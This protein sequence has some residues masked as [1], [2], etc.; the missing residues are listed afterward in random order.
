MRKLSLLFAFLLTMLGGTRVW[1]DELTV[2]NG[3][4]KNAYIPFMGQNADYGVKGEYVVPASDLTAMA[5]MAITSM[6][7]YVETNN[8]SSKPNYGPFQIFL[9]EINNATPYTSSSSAFQGLTDATVV[10]EGT[11]VASSGELLITFS[12]TYTYNG[13][14]LLIGFYKDKGGYYLSNN[15]YGVNQEGYTANSTYS[16]SGIN[17]ISTGTGRTFIP[18][19]TF[20]YE[21][22]SPYK[23]PATL[24]ISSISS[25]SAVVEWTAGSNDNSETGWDLE[26]KKSSE[27][28]WN[29]V[30]HGLS[31]STLSQT[32]SG[33]SDNTSYDVRVKALYS[34][35][36]E[37]DWRATSF[38]TA[39]VATPA[40][41]FTDNF[42]SDKEWELIN[43]TQTNK[44]VR[45]TATNNGGSN[46]L[47]ISNDGG[48][49]NAYGH[50]ASMTFATKLFAFETGNFTIAYDWKAN[51]ES[52]YDFMRVALVPA[53]EELT[54]G[55]T[56]SS[57]SYNGLPSGWQALDGGSKLNLQSDW[58]SKSVD[59][60]IES[61][62]SYQVVFAWKNDGN[63][64][65]TTPAAAIDNFKILGSA[66]VLELGGDVTGT[67]LAFGSV[68]ETTNKTITITNSGKVA[69]E[70]ITLTE[71]S[72]AN[73]V[74]SYTAL[75]K[76]TLAA[77]ESMDVT[78]TFSGSTANDYTGSFRVTADDCSAI[79]V[80]VTATYS[81]SPATIAVKLGDNVVSGTQA[82]GS[83]GKQAV[84]TFTVVNDGDQTLNVTIASNNTTDFT[85]SPASLAVTGHN[86]GT[87]TVTFVYP[88][89]NPVIN[90]EKS[91]NITVT[92]SNDG[93]SDV[94]FDVTGTRIELWSE[95]F[96]GTSTPTGW[97]NPVSGYTAWTFSEGVAYGGY[98]Y[99]N[100]ARIQ[101]PLLDVESGKSLT[102]EAKGEVSYSEFTVYAYS[103]DGVLVKTSN[104][105]S[106]VQASLTNF[107]TLTVDGLNAGKY[108]FV[109]DAYKTYVDRV[110]GFKLATL[111]AHEAEVESTTI[112]ATG[113]QY[114]AYT[115]SVNVK[116]TG[117]NSEELT[118][119]FFI[120]NTQY[121]S[122]VV[123]TVN[124]GE[125]ETFTVTF[126]PDAAVSGDAYFTFTNNDI[127]LTTSTTAV[128]IAAAT[129]LDE[130]VGLPDGLT[131]GTKP[132]LVLNYTVKAGWN[133]IAVPFALTDDILTSIFG[134]GYSVF[135]FDSYDN[136][137]IAFKPS[138]NF[139]AGY[140]YLVFVET[141]TAHADGV[142][143]FDVNVSTLTEESDYRNPVRFQTTYAPMAAG[144]MTG[145]YG[146]T[147]DGEIRKAGSGASLKGF[148]AYFTG[149]PAGTQARIAFLGD[150]VPTGINSIESVMQTENVYNLN[151]QKVNT[152][153]KGIY[154]VNGKKVL[155]K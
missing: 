63:G 112:P 69:M 126:T 107:T 155:V 27:T 61:A 147:S 12:E 16:S 76:I 42:E 3:T 99:P 53:S 111:E 80:T 39:K 68:S 109:F 43:G 102:I 130:M 146:V 83:V 2:A 48:T 1:A 44:W 25:N 119:K 133:T 125:T 92:P 154:I 65:T 47:Y 13:G 121:G 145:N 45:G 148:R 62:G 132:S 34:N 77:N 28:T 5:G 26:Y 17:S 35:N 127:A 81:N 70:N 52:N 9:K 73:N 79:D 135:E 94:T 57:F 59:I 137:V 36:N 86:S 123:K 49:T 72:D 15:F 75:P 100:N 14:N 103:K 143:L 122:D 30:H 142:K 118:A 134:T 54:A 18:K 41:G 10:Y 24:T 117:A 37:S 96:E 21:A 82:F 95:E 104:F 55:T 108:Y 33:L 153:Q 58:Q 114:V 131:T 88:T 46:A 32:I 152:P 84:K 29:E 11:I 93:L 141:A 64:G 136:N 101:T 60:T 113:N 74:F 138:T 23:K 20:T 31:V 124:S 144:S 128:T 89:E 98:S 78:V 7:L 4:T 149:V 22:T 19:T 67:T 90:E 85:V 106:N 140:P 8:S 51:G 71:T 110:E 50:S 115:A 56:P 38:K 105:N 120:G 139:V 40:T 97:T 151:G 91:A 6:K 150:D 87:F 129:V 116:V 66:P